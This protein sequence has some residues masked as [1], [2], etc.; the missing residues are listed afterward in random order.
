MT[1][2]PKAPDPHEEP[3]ADYGKSVIMVPLIIGG[4]VIISIIMLWETHNRNLRLAEMSRCE[5]A[6]RI[7]LRAA[8]AEMRALNPAAALTKT[9]EAARHMRSLKS[10]WVSDYA[11][12]RVALLLMEGEALMMRD[13]AA[14]APA[15][16]QRFNESLSLMVH[17]SG[18]LWQFGLLGRSKARFEQGKY[19]DAIADLD[20]VMTRNPNFGAAYYW[21]ALA[22]QKLGDDKGA[23]EDEA[24][25][26]SLDSWPPLRDF[27]QAANVYTRDILCKPDNGSCEVVVAPLPDNHSL[28]PIFTPEND[29]R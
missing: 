15:A 9:A 6:A 4:A 3:L 11:E 21:R 28:A 8:Y 13:G 5:E 26:R 23:R 12:L 29:D 22:K 7:E 24:R 27:M 1:A 18:E 20:H 14:N 10:T 2:T 16:E 19:Q 17:A 25:A